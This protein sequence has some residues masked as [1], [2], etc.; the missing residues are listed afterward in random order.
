MPLRPPSLLREV[1]IT[2][3]PKGVIEQIAE[4]RDH[5]LRYVVIANASILQTS[6]TKALL[7]TGPLI[8]GHS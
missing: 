1:F 4:W 7:S 8:S 3:T 2:G 6:L 5:V